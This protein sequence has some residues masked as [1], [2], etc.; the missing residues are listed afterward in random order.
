MLRNRP[1]AQ[2]GCEPSIADLL[3]DPTAQ[4]LMRADGVQV[5]EVLA[6]VRTLARLGAPVSGSGGTDAFRSPA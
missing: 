2:G 4:A 6:I 1:W 3:S 5:G